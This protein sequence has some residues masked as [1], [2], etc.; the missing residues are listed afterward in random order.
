M[1]EGFTRR[2][3]KTSGATIVTVEGGKG[4][5]L[6]LLHGNPFTHLSWHSVAPVLAK[7][8][9]VVCTDLRGYGDSSKPPDGE[10]HINYSFRAMAQDQI[11]VMETLGWKRFAV[12]GHD[13]GA[14]VSHR[15]CLDHPGRV[16]RA[17]FLD[18]LPQH[19]LLNN[20]NL[21][22]AVFSYHWFFM[23]Q[24]ADFPERLMGADPEYFI[25]RKLAK[26]AQGLSFFKPEALAEYIRCIKNPATI[27]AM[28]EDYRATVGVDLD[29]DTAD[30]AAGR[31]VDCP[32]LLLWGATGGVG[33]HHKPLEVW[34][35]YASDIR[36][37]V[38]LPCGHYLSEER[39]AETA[40]ELRAFFMDKAG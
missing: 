22:F 9:T 27:H 34:P 39:P 35:R 18:I 30:M 26:T 5:P 38:A 23:V 4:P 10:N 40:A 33:R 7:D 29:M 11:E 17:A 28:C 37:G 36:R 15:M 1:L 13:R 2:E 16:E 32:L 19:Y 8:F 14:R 21:G 6:L 12:A 3:I 31:K 24:P 20:I 25:R